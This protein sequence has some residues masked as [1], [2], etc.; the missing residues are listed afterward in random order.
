MPSLTATASHQSG[1]SIQTHYSQMSADRESQLSQ[2]TLEM[3]MEATHLDDQMQDIIR[4][5]KPKITRDEL[6]QIRSNR[7]YHFI[8][9]TLSEY[10]KQIWTQ[11][12]IDLHL[13]YHAKQDAVG[14][15]K[16][17]Y[18]NAKRSIKGAQAKNTNVTAEQFQ[19]LID[20]ANAWEAACQ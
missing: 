15:Y 9:N 18:E 10:E 19:G 16:Q 6:K 2:E 1:L 12:L 14:S 17:A 20:L 4:A 5:K 13:D 3:A 7:S 11:S 8:L